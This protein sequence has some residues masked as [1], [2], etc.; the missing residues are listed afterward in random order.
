MPLEQEAL[1]LDARTYDQILLALRERIPRYLP[2][3]TDYNE[4]D[5]GITLIELFAW[6]SEQ[7]L[8]EM[9]RVPQRSYIKFLKLLGQELRPAAPSRAYLTLTPAAGAQTSEAPPA[10]PNGAQFGAQPPGGDIVI[11]EAAEGVDL[12]RLPLTDVQVFDGAAFTVVSEAN[13]T[14]GTTFRPFGWSA[15]AGSALYL[16]FTRASPLV[17][18]PF[19]AQMTWRVFFPQETPGRRVARSEEILVEP[20]PP[21]ALAWEYRPADAPGSWRRLEVFDDRSA[22][23]TREGTIKVKG[24]TDAA[25][26]RE[27]RV[28]DERF[29]L[30]VRVADK[31]Y[32]TGRTPLIDFIRPNVAE[33]LSLAT[34]REEVLGQSTGQPDQLFALQHRPVRPD[35]LELDVTGP[36]PERR[37]T[38][39]TRKEDL[40]A[41][42]RDDEH[43]VLNA[44]AGEVRFG[45]G[46]RGLIPVAG[47]VVTA[48]SYQYGGGLRANVAP[49]M[50]TLP[51]SALTN[52]EAVTNERPAEGGSDEQPLD[53][54]LKS[55]PALLRHRNRAVSADDYATLA[56]ELGGVGKAIALAQ[57]HPDYPGVPVPGAVTVVVVPDTADPAPRP[58]QA[59]LDEVCRAL[60]PR[61]PLAT[62]LYV[63]EP[64]YIEITVEATVAVE[65]YASFDAVRQEIIAAINADLDPLGRFKPA[66]PGGQPGAAPADDGRRKGRDFGLDLF[67]TRLY[68]VIQRVPYVKL[69]SALVVNG[70]EGVEL[71]KRIELPP[72]G[73]VFGSARH[74]LNIVPY[75]EPAGRFV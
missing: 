16:G 2:E 1:Q 18:Q 59:L 27:G 44:T 38:R 34:V 41:A 7:L 13:A 64:H 35:T 47:S 65:P 39:W 37:R 26:S 23:F 73:L 45:D 51:L 72:H 6:L 9:G 61:R 24:P 28:K 5:P 43:Y 71:N 75:E 15:Q 62:E 60:D 19:P 63:T 31:P 56:E 52:L 33:V 11:F 69:V 46:E 42:G 30:R 10:V 68:S 54:F 70:Q 36:P 22:A 66:L 20:V 40:L 8:F 4:S 57:F 14:P 50:I 48:R 17:R 21:V 58:S 49:S 67:P 25:A 12:I 74:E 55:A 3:W 53:D 29:W 32:P